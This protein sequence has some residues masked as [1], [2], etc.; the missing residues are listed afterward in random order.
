MPIP[1][2]AV[3]S[4]ATARVDGRLVR[5]LDVILQ[6]RSFAALYSVWPP[7]EATR[8]RAENDRRPQRHVADGVQQVEEPV[9]L[10]VEDEVELIRLLVRQEAAPFESGCV[11]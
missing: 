5:R 7:S 9:G 10:Y 6:S 1:P 2:H 3:Q 11:Q 4:I 8:N